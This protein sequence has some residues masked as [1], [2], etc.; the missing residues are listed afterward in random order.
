MEILKTEILVVGAGGA[1][2]RAAIEASDHGAQVAVLS[3]S[4]LGKAH[5][6]MAEGGIAA[7]LGNADPKDN[8][9]VHFRDTMVEGQMIADWDM[10]S[11]LVQ[12]VPERIKELE[13]WGALFDRDENGKIAQRAFGAHTYKR[14]C[15]VGD[16]IGLEI[17]HTL[18]DQVIARNIEVRDEAIATKIIGS[19]DK[20]NNKNKNRI[21]GVICVDLK[22]GEV[23]AIQAKAIILA[24]GGAGRL[25]KIT[26]NS[27]ET[28]GYGYA[29]AFDAGAQLQDM[30]M[31][32]FHPTGMVYPQSAAGLL[33]TEAVRGEGGILLNSKGERFM[34][35]YDKKR[36]ELSARDIVARAVYNEIKEGRGTAHGGAW[37][38]IT[39]K[40]ANY[41]IKKL[42][43]MYDQFNTFAHVDIKK[44]KMEV[45]PTAH[46]TMGGVK[47][48][49]N[50]ETSVAGLFVAGEAATGVH[51]ANRLGGNS[52]A[53][54][55]VFG[56]RAGINAAKYSSKTEY[57]EMDKDEISEELKR[58]DAPFKSN[59]VHPSEIK[60]AAQKIMWEHAGIMKTEHG[61][62]QALEG[63]EKLKT[64]KAHADGSL[65][66]NLTWVEAIQA[67]G[68][69]LVCEAIVRSALERKESRGAHYRSDF[70][71]QDDKSWMVNIICR[72]M[73]GKMKLEK[74][75]VPQMPE[76]LKRLLP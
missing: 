14:T 65:Q 19:N 64:M 41:I 53:D 33:V 42:P 67:A 61:L 58:M 2:L 16:R 51:G 49:I 39:H 34:E 5:T 76:E 72:N 21:A 47:T 59:G 68:M 63:I 25:Y 23:F 52:L 37:L 12:E 3:K 4:V 73:K 45:A 71:K 46:Y 44:E 75:P 43:S 70:P 18:E 66:Y 30:E 31:I 24:T 40:G 6:V 56:R 22:R 35:K 38:D 20:N 36:M 28:A 57:A 10:V 9:K 55:L 50:C 48:N 17:L 54:I 32:Q 69:L 29:L 74:K 1:G 8:W 11:A 7:A 26:S 13:A 15:Y 27:W 62:R 60:K